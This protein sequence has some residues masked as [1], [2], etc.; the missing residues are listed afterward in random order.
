MPLI[1]W[2]VFA[3]IYY[4]TFIPNTAYAKLFTGIAQETYW[5]QGMLYAANSLRWDCITLITI[6]TAV[7]V[8]LSSNQTSLNI[9]AASVL[10][11]LGYV[12]HVGG[13]FMSGRFYS[14]PFVLSLSILNVRRCWDQPYMFKRFLALCAMLILSNPLSG[15]RNHAYFKS[16]PSDGIADEKGFYSSTNTLSQWMRRDPNIPFPPFESYQ[17]FKTELLT[18]DHKTTGV[19]VTYNIGMLGYRSKLEDIIIDGF[20]LTDPLL[21]RLPALPSRIGHFQRNFPAGYFE[22][23]IDKNHRNLMQDPHIATLYDDIRLIT[24]GPLWDPIRWKAILKH[25][26]P[27]HT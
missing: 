10:M 21:A 25:I 17:F 6:G 2:C 1:A 22:S 24:Q 4:G 14:A 27:I 15:I 20:A 5:D 9:L 23:L 11:Y 19:F 8:G 16:I 26:F 7:Y 3:L 13:D 12:T 18:A